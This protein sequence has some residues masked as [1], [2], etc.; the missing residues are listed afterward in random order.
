LTKFK[1]TEPSNPDPQPQVT[2]NYAPSHVTMY[3]DQRHNISAGSR[4]L[5]HCLNIIV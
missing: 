5:S 2:F 1:D 3:H 4:L